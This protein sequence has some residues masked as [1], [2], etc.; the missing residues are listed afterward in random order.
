[1][2]V[3]INTGFRWAECCN[4]W[5]Y[6]TLLLLGGLLRKTGILRNSRR[7][8]CFHRMAVIGSVPQRVP[9]STALNDI[10][11]WGKKTPCHQRW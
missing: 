4:S 6:G 10:K 7:H 2:V 8:C 9:A 1:M 3:T 11:T 5:L